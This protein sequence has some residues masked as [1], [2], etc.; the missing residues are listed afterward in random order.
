[1]YPVVLGAN[2]G[3]TVTGMLAALAA[4]GDKLRFT[5][6]VAFAHL[7]FNLCGILV[8]YVVW[9]LRSVPIAMARRLGNAT[10]AHRW[11]R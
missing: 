9:P 7:F 4:D 1:M 10:A 2:I 6:A 5:L 8:W 3:T 11:C